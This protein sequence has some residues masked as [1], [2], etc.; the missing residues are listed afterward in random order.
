MS[1]RIHLT[2]ETVAA[3]HAARELGCVSRTEGAMAMAVSDCIENAHFDTI[4]ELCRQ[5]REALR[6]EHYTSDGTP[7]CNILS[8]AQWPSKVPDRDCPQ[9][10]ALALMPDDTTEEVEG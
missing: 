1:E 2:P 10:R 7:M 4:N 6:N 9:C 3:A 8:D 5:L